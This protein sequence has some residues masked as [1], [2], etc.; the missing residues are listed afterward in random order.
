MIRYLSLEWLDALT[1]EVAASAVLQSMAGQHTI[2]VTQVVT[3]GPEGTVVYHLQVGDGAAHFGA[4]AAEPEHVRMEQTWET[5]VG[6]A[7]G[8][9]NAQ[10]AFIKGRIL[11]SGNQQ[12]LVESQPVFGAL[13][14]V[15]SSVR[16]RTEY[17]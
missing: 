2:G 11:L 6:V 8:E 15:F 16:E 3:D 1:A 17:R 10:E 13:D 4:G 7:T 12:R 14:A 5:A 9:L